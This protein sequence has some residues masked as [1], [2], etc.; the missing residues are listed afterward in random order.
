MQV[1]K[2]QDWDLNN[3]KVLIVAASWAESIAIKHS[4]YI[5]QNDRNFQS[6]RYIAFYKDGR[7][8]YIYEIVDVPYYNCTL[9]NTPILR[10]LDKLDIPE[11]PRQVIYIKLFL[12]VDPI[13]NDT[14]DKN[15]KPCAFTQGHRYT[16]FDLIKKAKKTSELV[17]S[18]DEDMNLSPEENDDI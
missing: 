12:E 16:T 3:D 15:G 1:V 10:T 9:D 11:E 13:V 14:L 6:S 7:I 8:K 2:K 5:C 4:I 18:D 17:A